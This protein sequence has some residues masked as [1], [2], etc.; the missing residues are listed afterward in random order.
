ML[1]AAKRKLEEIDDI[2]YDYR[3]FTKWQDR[4]FYKWAYTQFDKETIDALR[5]HRVT[6]D[7]FCEY[8]EGDLKELSIMS[9][10]IKKIIRLISII[11]NAI[12]EHTLMSNP[13]IHTP[14]KQH[15]SIYR[16]YKPGKPTLPF[17]SLSVVPRA[18]HKLTSNSTNQHCHHT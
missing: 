3:T 2:D 18:P 14:I 9:G 13:N 8:T 5:K 11:K 17:S 16:S 1:G 10:Q 6:A 7:V 4:D 15:E 12:N